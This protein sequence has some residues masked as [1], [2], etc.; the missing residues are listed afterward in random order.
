MRNSTRASEAGEIEYMCPVCGL[1]YMSTEDID[2]DELVIGILA[3]L[4]AEDPEGVIRSI[5][6]NIDGSWTHVSDDPEQRVPM[7]RKKRP[8]LTLAQA[9]AVAGLGSGAVDLDSSSESDRAPPQRRMPASG[10][11]EVVDLVD[12]DE[13]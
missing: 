11:A 5:N 1:E 3:E 13:D 7:V 6:L 12:S 10:P 2:V 4:D 8:R 9:T